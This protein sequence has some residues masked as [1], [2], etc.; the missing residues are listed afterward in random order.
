MIATNPLRGGL[1]RRMPCWAAMACALLFAPLGAITVND[2]LAQAR[3][4]PRRFANHFADFTFE[5]FPY[6][7]DPDVFLK[8]ENGCCQDYAILGSFILNHAKFETHLIRVLLVG[9]EAHDVCYVTQTGTYL[10]YNLRDF[11][12]NTK[13]SGRRI[14]EIAGKVAASFD[15]NWTS[16]SEFTYTYAED[17]KRLTLTVVKTD[18]PSEDPDAG[19]HS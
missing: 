6:V 16:A 9:G 14:R 7:Q 17:M 1:M 13:H 4:T 5:A 10:D 15:E 2:L 18:P 19:E 11:F 8:T 12:I 3:M